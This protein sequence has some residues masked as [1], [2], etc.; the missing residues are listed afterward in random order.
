MTARY[1][2]VAFKSRIDGIRTEENPALV[3]QKS[4]DFYWY[5]PTLKRQL[6]TV[7]ADIVASPTSKADV[8]RVLQAAYA[9]GIPV[10]PRGMGS[11]K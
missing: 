8:I 11:C 10:P 3:R 1:D 4:R 7:T 6:E 5:S 2:I 9:F